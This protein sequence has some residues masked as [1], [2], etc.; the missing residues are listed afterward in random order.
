MIPIKQ[1][2]TDY[3]YTWADENGNTIDDTAFGGSFFE[4]EN[5]YQILIYYRS[6]NN[7]YD[8]IIAFTALNTATKIRNY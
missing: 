7:R 5:D 2:I 4:T 6:P 8:E 1:G 3:H